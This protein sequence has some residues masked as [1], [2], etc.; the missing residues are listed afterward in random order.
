[1]VQ[2]ISGF[3]KMDL[4]NYFYTTVSVVWQDIHLAKRFYDMAAETSLDAY[5]PVM[6][7]LGKLALYFR[8]EYAREVSWRTLK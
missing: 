3:M 4:K 7:A 2:I 6:I 5:I 8:W 1:M